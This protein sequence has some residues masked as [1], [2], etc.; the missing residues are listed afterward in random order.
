MKTI[1]RTKLL[2][3]L[4][5]LTSLSYFTSCSKDRKE[6]NTD[7]APT[8]AFYTN[9]APPEQTFII[10]SLGGDTIVGMDG[11]K[12][13]GVPKTI[14]ML[15]STHQDIF[16]P[17]FLKLIEAYSVK[18]MIL[19]R[20]TNVAQNKILK[21]SGEFKITAFKDT[22]TLLLKDH[23]GIPLWAPSSTPDSNM[24]VYYGFTAGT[25]NDWN[26]DVTQTDYLFASDT[27][28][29]IGVHGNGY[30]LKITK[31]GWVEIARQFT[32]TNSN[33]SFTS[34]GT[35]TN[36][37]DV[38][39]VFNNRHSFIKVNSLAANDLPTGEPI[40]VFALAMDSGGQMY[41]FKQNFNVA[42][43][44]VIDLLMNQ[45]TEA[46]VLAEMATL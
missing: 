11:T 32:Y 6:V 1:N 9:N 37:I 44:L 22:N 31:L 46:Q 36:F 18:N 30:S 41:Y 27:V 3:A 38:Y 17:F 16:Y 21:T 34:A 8:D 20:L 29:N 4:I 39:V 19:S 14:F 26:N 15:K 24:N 28:T 2:L 10:D 43:G 5:A 45:A 12:I 40:T 13:W 23:C 42:N 35:N 25:A 33:I 7:Y